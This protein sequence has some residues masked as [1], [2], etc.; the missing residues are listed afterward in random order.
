MLTNKMARMQSIRAAQWKNLIRVSKA[1]E[2]YHRLELMRFARRSGAC[3]HWGLLD[4]F[5]LKR[6]EVI[7]RSCKRPFFAGLPLLAR[8]LGS[9]WARTS[10]R[11]DTRV[12]QTNKGPL[13]TT[14][15]L[16]FPVTPSTQSWNSLVALLTDWEELRTLGA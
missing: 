6:R 13:P 16:A 9:L 5:Q 10:S 12:P 2:V 3:A 8:D 15:S 14:R 11:Y 4:S 1:L 7:E